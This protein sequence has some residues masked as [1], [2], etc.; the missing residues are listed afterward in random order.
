MNS[1]N[2]RTRLLH[3]QIAEFVANG[4]T[5]SEACV[6]FDVSLATVRISCAEHGVKSLERE[7]KAAVRRMIAEAIAAGG[8]VGATA[9]Q[10]GVSVALVRNAMQ[11]HGVEAGRKRQFAI[12]PVI[13]AFLNSMDDCPTIAKRLGMQKSVVHRILQRC[14][15]EGIRMPHRPRRGEAGR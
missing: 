7:A 11:E 4:A 13:A 8:E 14:R 12:V 6:Q 1:L 15:T 3:R 2:R 9:H 5:F 10:F